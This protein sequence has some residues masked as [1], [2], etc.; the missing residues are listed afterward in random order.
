MWTKPRGRSRGGPS[1]STDA[2]RCCASSELAA[3]AKWSQ[4][5]GRTPSTVSRE[6]RRGI[7]EQ[8][9]YRPYDAHR[10]AA[11]RRRR[12]RCSR[13]VTNV[14][15]LAFVRDHLERRWSPAQI[16]R[17][18]RRQHPDDRTMWVAPE[19]I[20]QEIYRPESLLRRRREVPSWLRTGRDHRRAHR[21]LGP[22]RRRFAGPMLM[23]TDRP[24]D[25]SDRTVP[26]HWEGDLSV[27][28]AHRSAIGTLV[29]RRTRYVKLTYLIACDSTTLHEALV[30]ALGPLPL[31]LRRSLTWDQGTEMARH[32]DTAARLGARCTSASPPAPGS[33]GRTR[34]PTGSCGSTSPK[35]RTCPCTPLP[36]SHASNSSSISGPARSWTTGHR[37]SYLPN[38]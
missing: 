17:E 31:Q 23:I 29:E 12:P 14:L 2:T 32:L 33:A 1:S 4:T 8:G 34:T 3:R 26:G 38:C 16:S 21:R 28:P 13:F 36:T 27:G 25:P 30:R 19:S 35:A 9:R 10:R 24:F 7:D 20:Y 18:L 6:L 37:P 11:E 5:L 22:R 15:L